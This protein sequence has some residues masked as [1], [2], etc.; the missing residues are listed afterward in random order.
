MDDFQ[1]HMKKFFDSNKDIRTCINCKHFKIIQESDS[2][3]CLNTDCYILDLGVESNIS[4][5]DGEFWEGKLK[6]KKEPEPE[7]F[8]KQDEMEI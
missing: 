7:E 6:W 5:C 3:V 8:I 4:M 1:K 2:Y